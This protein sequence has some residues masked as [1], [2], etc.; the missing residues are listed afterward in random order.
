M[1]TRSL[2]VATLFLIRMLCLLLFCRHCKQ[3]HREHFACWLMLVVGL[4]A[5]GS[6]SRCRGGGTVACWPLWYAPML[7]WQQTES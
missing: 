5:M 7:V 6:C 1:G 2:V 4:L 3:K